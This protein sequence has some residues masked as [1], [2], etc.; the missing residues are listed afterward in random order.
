MKTKLFIDTTKQVRACPFLVQR[1]EKRREEKKREKKRTEQNRR[2]EGLFC[3]SEKRREQNRR[4][5]PI[6]WVEKNT[7]RNG[8]VLLKNSENRCCFAV[9]LFCCFTVLL[10]CCSA[11]QRRDD[12]FS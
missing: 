2:E 12:F 6:L 11:V 1:E 3:C 7:K 8:A 5:E 4:E 9:L 10:F